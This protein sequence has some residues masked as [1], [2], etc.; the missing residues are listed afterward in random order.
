MYVSHR[1]SPTILRT[2][3]ELGG[4]DGLYDFDTAVHRSIVQ[5]DSF[6][7]VTVPRLSSELTFRLL[8]A[9]RP[10]TEKRLKHSYV[11][12]LESS[13]NLVLSTAI[14]I[15]SLSLIGNEYYECVWPSIGSTFNSIEMEATNQESEVHTDVVRLPLCPGLRAY[16]KQGMVDYHEL[17]HVM[18]S[19]AVTKY[20]VKAL[21]MY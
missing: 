6:K 17:N 18:S 4:H 19:S 14:H 13:L 10:L 7:A 12:K 21:V 5:E 1:P 9:L 8:N 3:N 2:L 16:S 15:R 11:R 20:V